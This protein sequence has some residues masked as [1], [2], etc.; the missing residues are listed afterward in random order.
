MK[1]TKDSGWLRA[2]ALIAATVV[3]ASGTVSASAAVRTVTEGKPTQAAAAPADRQSDKS[4]VPDEMRDDLL[5]KGWKDSRDIAWTLAGDSEG[6]RILLASRSEGYAW[7]QVA[8]LA[9]PGLETD[10]WIGNACLTADAEWLA[11]VYAPR[12]YTN[13]ETLFGMGAYA[14][15]VPT[16]GGEVV[17]V[18]GRY[19]LSYFNPGCGRTDEIALTRFGAD[20]KTRIA[21]LHAGNPAAASVYE[22]DGQYTSAVPVDGQ[23]MAVVGNQIVQLGP[24]NETRSL[25]ET[26]GSPFDLQILPNSDIAYLE[27]DGKRSRAIY[28]SSSGGKYEK[29]QK[30]AE[31]ELASVGIDSAA[32]G[33]VVI[34]GEPD[35]TAERLPKNILVSR[36]AFPRAGLSSEAKLAVN[37]S[38]LPT[39]QLGAAAP[40]P[41]SG[42][43]IAIK[44]KDLTT[45]KDVSFDVLPAADKQT[46]KPTGSTDHPSG[47][48]AASFSAIATS[49]TSPISEG[50]P[51]AIPRND[52]SIQALQ[53]RPSEVEWYV[54]KAVV[55][56]MNSMF[57]LP[58]LQGT[59]NGKVPAQVMLGIL[60]QESN[61]WQASRYSVPGVSGNPL[62]GNYYG[63]DRFSSDPDAWW[64]I[65][66][67]DADCGYGVAQITD[68]MR[69]GQ[70]PYNQQL[71]IATNYQAN[72]SR[73]IQMIIE[74]WNETRA[75]GLIIHDGNPKF[76]EN[77]FYAVWAYNT[78]FHAPGAEG[79]PWGVGW[80]NNPAN[81]AYPANRTPF[82]D[83][84]PADAAHPQDWP[85]PEKVLGF[86]AHSTQFV[87][88]VSSGTL[89][90][91]YHYGPAFTAAWWPSSDN[92]EG[93]INRYNV[94]PPINQFCD[95]TNWCDIDANGPAGACLHTTPTNI[96]DSKCWYNQP[97]QW[98][99]DCPS[100]CGQQT[101]AYINDPKPAPATS[102]PAACQ[103]SSSIPQGVLVVDSV[104]SNVSTPAC[105]SKVTTTGSFQFNFAGDTTNNFPSKID[106][107]QLGSGF[108]GQFYFSHTRVPG[109]DAAEGGALDITGTWNL[110]Q[111]LN[112][113]ARVY[114][115]MPNH[116]AWLQQAEY[117]VNTGLTTVRRSVN[118]R[119][120]ANTW[121]SLGAMQFAGTPTVTLA[122][123]SAS[124]TDSTVRDYLSGADDIAWDAVAFEVLPGKPADFIVALGDSFSSGEGTSAH[125]GSGFWRGSDHH[126]EYVMINDKKRSSPHRNACHRS[127]DAWPTGIIPPNSDGEAN[128]GHLT[129]SKSPLVDFH[130]LACAGAITSSV[131]P[132][133][134]AGGLQQYAEDT[135]LDRGFLDSNTT[136]VT[137]TIGG[138]DVGFG[139]VLMTCITHS[140]NP[141]TPPGAL[142]KDA[143]SPELG[144][145]TLETEVA[146]NLNALPG[147]IT[148]VLQQVRA[149]AP[150]AKI[151]VLGYPTLFETSSS[152]VNIRNENRTWLNDVAADL[153]SKLTEGV[154]AAAVGAEYQSPQ[155]RFAMTHSLCE[156]NSGINGLIP[157][158]TPGDLPLAEV[159]LPGNNLGLG[160][161]AQSI[162]PNLIGS[163]IYALVANELK[164]RVT[165]PVSSTLVGGAST[166]YYATFRLHAGGPASFNAAQ[167]SACGQEMRVGLRKQDGA[168]A[169]GQQH[170]D[171]LS[172]T[173]PHAMQNF[174]WTATSSPQLPAGSYAM[175]ARLTTA[176]PGGGAQPWQGTL[177]LRN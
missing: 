64:Q 73:G 13:D 115:H 140:L 31:G 167:F 86:A 10:R 99:T 44:A 138:N 94:K 23:A 146:A 66:Y 89:G 87:D 163:T 20:V 107:H 106:L 67:E 136:L 142:C 60:A 102:F 81:N 126:G 8:M 74:K 120:Y 92:A 131:L 169:F 80:M 69:A 71:A 154:H 165:Y 156:A 49:P 110:G 7:K 36:S 53:P 125:D 29:G 97:S 14:A 113:W 133:S 59:T 123:N 119:N 37:E 145:G 50:S 157:M 176:C 26:T 132:T 137:L 22:R 177:H 82:L 17:H 135:Q 63:T 170:T 130:L 143:S 65:S 9:R 144:P 39:A 47:E 111:P 90:D 68:G 122:N 27:H 38:N 2:V 55:S 108:N 152:C 84:S 98:K 72:I 25:V 151:L 141:G 160:F 46:G 158:L 112:G 105:S 18:D 129:S 168:G 127:D 6:L 3:L 16:G 12:A 77:W 83:G 42:L 148:S 109:S 43:T 150:N 61:F 88:S 114:V 79:E 85:Y 103:L 149:K 75:A 45:A 153:N 57:P 134:G 174:V 166:T 58:A 173:T 35:S 159:P 139:P 118:Q 34:S 21:V 56:T 175:N 4:E 51:C 32:N 48:G 101:L 91:T 95:S 162:H 54:D 52:P 128:V 33:T 100:E 161:S 124:Y 24:G 104:P 164:S 76:L 93:T 62:V 11:V 70:M 15:L 155:Y 30:L 121:V 116:G 41:E 96:Y 171:S 5:G 78:G 40:A 1:R 117:A 28:H 172:W 147:Q 19:S